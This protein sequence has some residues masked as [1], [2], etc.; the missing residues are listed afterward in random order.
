MQ[1]KTHKSPNF[2]D[3]KSIDMIVIHHTAMEDCD[4]VLRVLSDPKRKVSAHYVVDRDGSIYQLVD[5]TKAAWHAGV[6][7]WHGR[8]SINQYSIG[9]EIVNSGFAPFSDAQ[10]DA[11]TELCKYLKAKYNIDDKNIV[12]HADVAPNRKVDPSK[13]FDWQKL[14]KAG[15][16]IYSDVKL[17]KPTQTIAHLDEG[18]HVVE[19]REKLNKFGYKI[20]TS[21]DVFDLEMYSVSAAFKRHYSQESYEIAGWDTL[22]ELRLKDLLEQYY[23]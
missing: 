16:G 17:D 13:Y 6:S 5:D 2:S 11:V 4:A 15:V 19:L 20:D 9:I 18:A 10:M 1:F 3:R 23:A 21:K 8:E 12:G 7:S 14:F 22:A